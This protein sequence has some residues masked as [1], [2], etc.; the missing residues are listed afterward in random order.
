MKRVLKILAFVAEMGLLAGVLWFANS[1][2]GNPIS[3]SI[4]TKEAKAY[5]EKNYAHV[6][7]YIERV[8]FNFK[9]TNYYAV[10]KSES[11]VDTHF[12]I[13]LSGMGKVM[14][15]TYDSVENKWNTA[16]R[17][18]QEY[19]ELTDQVFE[20]E[21]FPYKEGIVYGSLEIGRKEDM[22]S[23]GT[24]MPEYALIQD[25]LEL[26]GVYDIRAIGAQS[27]E[28]VLYVDSTTVTVEKAARVLLEIKQY[29]DDAGVPFRAIDFMLQY[30][31]SEEA[32][33]EEEDLIWIENFLYENLYAEGLEERIRQA[34]EARRDAEKDAGKW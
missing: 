9:N 30:P 27:G 24:D 7:C 10:V 3:K 34:D 15:D 33:G 4:A 16:R 5:L 20:S 6:D 14:Y 11:S 19:R 29:M 12:S 21:S 17:L 28:L 26:D 8:D 22:D 13:Y 31:P 32:E 2:V 23:V 25:D 1:L 18:D